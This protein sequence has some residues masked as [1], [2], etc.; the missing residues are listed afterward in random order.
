VAWNS[1][2]HVLV[3]EY[4]GQDSDWIGHVIEL[5]I[6]YYTNKDGEQ[7]ENILVKA[8]TSRDEKGEVKKPIDKDLDDQI[9][10]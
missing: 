8:V 3:R 7:K 4:G 10:F 9:P 2:C 6:G 5:S 1:I